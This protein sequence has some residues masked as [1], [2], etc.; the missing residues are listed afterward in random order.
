MRGWFSKFS[1]NYLLR[2]L[3][4]FS[5][6]LLVIYFSWYGNTL[7]PIRIFAVFFHEASHAFATI[8]TGG[9]VLEFVVN[10]NISGHVQVRGGNRAIITSA[11]YI[12]TTLWGCL[13]YILAAKFRF[14]RWI[15]G[16]I[17][18]SVGIL[19][20]Y[21]PA[22]GI[23]LFFGIGLAFILLFLARFASD[24]WCDIIL[25]VTALLLMIR[26]IFSL[27]F[28]IIRFRLPRDIT[29]PLKPISDAHIMS[30]A[31]GGTPSFWAWV[32]IAIICVAIVLTLIICWRRPSR[33][34]SVSVKPRKKIKRKTKSLGDML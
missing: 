13:F 23:T 18:L 34:K 14:D 16:I 20:I 2:E 6:A 5:L 32:W 11:G 27:Y 31:F 9:S 12:G 7:Y 25:R 28:G 4:L 17:G 10:P 15:V 3:T 1:T 24:F 33:K 8:F 22:G 29:Q 26:P 30:R 21:F 19:T